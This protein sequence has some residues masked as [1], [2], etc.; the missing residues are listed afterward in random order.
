MATARCRHVL[1]GLVGVLLGAALFLGGSLA[2]WADGVVHGFYFYSPEC[3]HCEAIGSDVLPALEARFGNRLELLRFDIREPANYRV[4]LALEERY[5][6]ENVGLP[7]VFIG[8]DVL[9][10]EDAVR[11]GLERLVE[12]YLEAGGVDFPTPDL[13]VAGGTPAPTATPAGEAIINLA[14][15]Y[16]AGCR[17]CERVAYDLEVLR[18]RF[19]GLR[20][21]AFDISKEHALNEALAERASFPDDQRLVTPA[22]FVGDDA[23]VGS[24]ITLPR[25]EAVIER[26]AETGAP[27]VWEMVRPE[28]AVESI[29]RRFRSF[30]VLT[31]V[32]A[33]L[34]DGLN[35][36][37]FATIVFFISYLSFVGRSRRDL[38]LTGAAFTGGVFLAY[39]LVGLGALR[40]L[41]AVSGLAVVGRAIYGLMALLCVAFAVLSVHDAWQARR[42]KPEAMRLRLP[43]SLQRHVH[44][45]IRENTS[46]PAFVGMAAV[47]GLV[48]SVLELACTGQVYL[49]TILFVLGRPELRLQAASYL[50]LY[51]LVFVL[52]LIVVFVVAALGA[53][54]GR[55]AVLANKHTALIKLLTAVAFV[56]LGVWLLTVVL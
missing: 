4:L 12:K 16:Q 10:G 27:P 1:Q 24:E 42:S 32:G 37:A 28:S 19:P 41:A 11:S 35:P 44:R 38:L 45:V 20:V 13:P 52:P 47:T 39:L 26:Y 3:S 14:Y 5:G 48:V 7:E 49:P 33:G 25:L 43:K 36:C 50:V 17:Q 6:V 31:V 8:S 22:I 53:E 55:L 34:I 51:N 30:G 18:A 29:V 56:V 46:R 9:V 54:S 2:V 40:F 21:V 23:L 15:F